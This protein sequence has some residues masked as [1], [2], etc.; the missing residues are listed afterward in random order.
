MDF[1]EE[2]IKTLKLRI[3]WDDDSAKE[4]SVEQYLQL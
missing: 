3:T 1:I 4:R 2:H